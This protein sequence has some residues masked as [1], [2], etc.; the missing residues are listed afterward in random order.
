MQERFVGGGGELR[1]G[2]GRSERTEDCRLPVRSP[3]QIFPDLPV[4]SS[5]CLFPEL[6]RTLLHALRWMQKRLHRGADAGVVV[7]GEELLERD[8]DG[9]V[10]PGVARPAELE[11]V[12]ALPAVLVEH[13]RLVGAEV[14]V[15]RELTGGVVLVP[16]VPGEAEPLALA[17]LDLVEVDED[18][19]GGLPGRELRDREPG[20]LGSAWSPKARLG[21]ARS[22][23]VA[24]RLKVM[25][26]NWSFSMLRSRSIPS[27]VVSQV[28][29]TVIEPSALVVSV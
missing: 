28:W 3:Q 27:S 26:V 8:G 18:R 29:A 19:V 5:P 4:S 6:Q 12:V 16:E 20:A 7:S 22:A 21:G 17:E 9:H 14:V 2:G 10:D 1:E 11:D 24:L 15:A 13:E 25:S 23:G